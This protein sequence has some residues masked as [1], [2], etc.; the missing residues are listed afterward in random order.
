MV[1]EVMKEPIGSIIFALLQNA[2]NIFSVLL[3][4]DKSH[5]NNLLLTNHFMILEFN[6]V[7]AL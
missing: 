1:E 7:L 5:F 3:K 2:V 4:N 6:N